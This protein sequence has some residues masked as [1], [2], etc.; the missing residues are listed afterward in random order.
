MSE[1]RVAERQLE[2][3]R[4][5]RKADSIYPLHAKVV[6]L[7]NRADLLLVKAVEMKLMLKAI[8]KGPDDELAHA[9]GTHSPL[10]G[11]TPA[12]RTAPMITAE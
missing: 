1:Q 7:R 12:M 8:R 6:A 4:R 11:T 9:P 10:V 3:A 5:K 2:Y